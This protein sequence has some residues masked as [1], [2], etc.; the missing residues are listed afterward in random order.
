MFVVEEHR[1]RDI[2]RSNHAVCASARGATTSVSG[3]SAFLYRMKFSTV[4]KIRIRN[5][6]ANALFK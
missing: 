5:S 1:A 2:S 4:A 6:G 3:A